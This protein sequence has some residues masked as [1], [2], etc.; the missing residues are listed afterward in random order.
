MIEIKVSIVLKSSGLREQS[1]WRRWGDQNLNEWFE[2]KIYLLLGHV[3]CLSQ[4]WFAMV[5]DVMRVNRKGKKCLLATDR[6]HVAHCQ[7]KVCNKNGHR[8]VCS[9]VATAGSSASINVQKQHINLQHAWVTLLGSLSKVVHG[10]A[11]TLLPF[12]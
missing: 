4:K 6:I 3:C 5:P 12:V 11:M 9:K 1:E 8:K 10:V 7:A 2:Q